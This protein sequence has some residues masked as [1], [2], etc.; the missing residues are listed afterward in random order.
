MGSASSL[1]S[2]GTAGYTVGSPIAVITS[3]EKG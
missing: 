1:D 2:G 3:R